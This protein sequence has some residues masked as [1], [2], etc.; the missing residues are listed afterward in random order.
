[1]K[2]CHIHNDYTNKSNDSLEKYVAAAKAKGI[3]ELTVTEL[4]EIIDGVPPFA[5]HFIN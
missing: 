4:V 3:D 1:M 2:D 5:L